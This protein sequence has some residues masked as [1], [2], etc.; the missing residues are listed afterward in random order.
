MRPGSHDQ[1]RVTTATGDMTETLT[2]RPPFLECPVSLPPLTGR[3]RIRGSHIQATQ[4]QGQRL[5]PAVDALRPSPT[6]TA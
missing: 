2:G 3:T 5:I 4:G 6:L 1:A